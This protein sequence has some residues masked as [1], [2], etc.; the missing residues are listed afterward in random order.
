MQTVNKYSVPSLQQ[1]QEKSHIISKVMIPAE[2]TSHIISKV[3]IPAEEIVGQNV[4]SESSEGCLNKENKD[5]LIQSSFT[6]VSFSNELNKQPC[7]VCVEQTFQ[8]EKLT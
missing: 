4:Y 6:P 1:Q 2:E 7:V 3:M 8:E 5:P